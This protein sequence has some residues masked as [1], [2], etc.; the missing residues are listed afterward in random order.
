MGGGLEVG[1]GR[2]VLYL[3]R[4]RQVVLV[5]DD[6][7]DV[8]DLVGRYL[9]SSPYRVVGAATA[10]EALRLAREALPQVVLL[11]VMMPSRDGWEI[12]QSLKHNPETQHIPVVICSVL[13]ERAL[14]Y[15]LGADDYLR[16]PIT[17]DK[18]AAVLARL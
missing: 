1:E 5:V 16:K 17:Q 6:N 13:N 8:V 7:S 3:A 9:A 2:L 11:D 14:A 10:D 4:Q 18:L 12:L 15:S